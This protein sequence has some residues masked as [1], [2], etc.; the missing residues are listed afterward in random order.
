MCYAFDAIYIRGA[1]MSDNPSD[2]RGGDGRFLPG[3]S[4]N[5]TGRPKGAKGRAT[6]LTETL[7][8]GEG[9]V[10][11]R[12]MI[13]YATA[14]NK[15][16]LGFCLARLVPRPRGAFLRLELE[17]GAER[18]PVAVHAAAAR[19]LAD[20][21]MTPDEAEKIARFLEVAAKFGVKAA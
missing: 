17:D 16:A 5:P 21:E 9:H 7:K 19:A 8:D 18:S 1:P 20:G 11:M 14:G 4:G 10:M 2:A 6:L 15:T 3:Q 13:D 12:Q